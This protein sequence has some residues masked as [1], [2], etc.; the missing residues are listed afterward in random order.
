MSSIVHV[1]QTDTHYN[2]CGIHYTQNFKT[3][4]AYLIVSEMA[5]SRSIGHP[6]VDTEKREYSDPKRL[7]TYFRFLSSDPSTVV[8]IL[9]DNGFKL[10]NFSYE[11]NGH[12]NIFYVLVANS[13]HRMISKEALPMAE[14]EAVKDK[15]DI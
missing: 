10:V 2:G 11:C 9:C 12:M 1:S 5:H 13:V 4:N 7:G 15:T 6:K 8:E 3:Y 14:A